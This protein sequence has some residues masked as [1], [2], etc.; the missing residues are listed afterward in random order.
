MGN[1]PL[2]IR[3][4]AATRAIAE[5]SGFAEPTTSRTQHVRQIDRRHSDF[6]NV[7]AVTSQK[8]LSGRAATGGEL[9]F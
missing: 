6:Y 9:V 8:A 4:A 7:T 2:T 3:F 1:L 5:Q